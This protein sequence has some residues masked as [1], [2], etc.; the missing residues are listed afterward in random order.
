MVARISGRDQGGEAQS[1]H[2]NVAQ[3]LREA[4]TILRKAIIAIADQARVAASETAM[5]GPGTTLPKLYSLPSADFH[6]VTTGSNGGD[7]GH[8]IARLR[9]PNDTCAQVN[10]TARCV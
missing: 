7:F 2:V 8:V 6:D 10:D 4:A 9:F 1:S 5:D 3:A